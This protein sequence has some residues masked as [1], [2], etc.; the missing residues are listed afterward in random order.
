MGPNVLEAYIGN[1]VYHL[2]GTYV[3]R[4]FD[5]PTMC[6]MRERESHMVIELERESPT[7][8]S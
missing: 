6:P 4:G 5:P 7:S 8:T 3:Q 2:H 1:N